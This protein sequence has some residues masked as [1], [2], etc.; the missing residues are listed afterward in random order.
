M[1]KLLDQENIHLLTN[2]INRIYNSGTVPKDWLKSVFIP[3]PKKK[4]LDFKLMIL[5]SHTLR[6]VLK[7][8]HRCN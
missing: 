6:R 8:I 2:I 5:M 7:I 3:I 1:L 4:A